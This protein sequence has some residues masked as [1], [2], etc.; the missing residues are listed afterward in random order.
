MIVAAPKIRD[1]SFSAHWLGDVDEV[2]V[3]NKHKLL[4]KTR[5]RREWKDAETSK[6]TVNVQSN[7]EQCALD[8]TKHF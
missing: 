4:L 2:C 7:E 5:I 3:Q 1:D 6:S 8:S